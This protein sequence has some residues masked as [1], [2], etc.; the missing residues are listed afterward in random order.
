ML[1]RFFD[2]I[3]KPAPK[4]PKSSPDGK[5]ARNSQSSAHR[6]EKPVKPWVPGDIISGRYKVEE[7][8]SGSMGTVYITEHLGWGIKIAIKSPRP[9]ILSDREGMRCIRKE[10]NSWI[11][12][13]MHPNI[14]TCYFV[15]NFKKIPHL[16]IEY[17]DGGSLADWIQTG[18]CRDLRT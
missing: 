10:A 17:V 16:F 5:R 6:S 13:G 11:K 4:P 2:K 7:I 3:K 1:T 14:A 12:M 9:E 18:K 15:L 8:M